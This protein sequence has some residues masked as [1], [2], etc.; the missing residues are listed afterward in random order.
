VRG[1]QRIAKVD[2]EIKPA[3]QKVIDAI[4]TKFNIDLNSI[5]SLV[6]SH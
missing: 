2:G 5:K 4:A 1:C 6:N 3:E